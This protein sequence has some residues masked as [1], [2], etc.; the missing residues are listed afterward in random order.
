[1]F[2]IE[3]P[4]DDYGNVA[5]THS[6]MEGE[7]LPGGAL[8]ITAPEHLTGYSGYRWPCV[9]VEGPARELSR[10]EWQQLVTQVTGHDFAA[11]LARAHAGSQTGRRL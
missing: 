11:T 8:V 6:V 10:E 1:V 9:E 4:Q 5:I 3:R 2:F 7:I